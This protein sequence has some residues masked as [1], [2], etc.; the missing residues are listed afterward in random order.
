LEQ[1]FEMARQRAGRT[2]IKTGLMVGLGETRAELSRTLADVRQ[3]GCQLITIGQYLRPTRAQ[4]EV[5]RYVEPSEFAE[6]E[7]EARALGFEEV[8][9]GPLVRSSYRA[10]ALYGAVHD[11][12]RVRE[13]RK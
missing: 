7:F 2:L 1:A 10:D 11:G 13:V 5:E 8:A 3:T 4:L 12:A 6:I 9:A